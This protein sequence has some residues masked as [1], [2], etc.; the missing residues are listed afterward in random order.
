MFG[1]LFKAVKD[2]LHVWFFHTE[3]I[4]WINNVLEEFHFLFLSDSFS[5]KYIYICTDVS[6]VAEHITAENMS[7]GCFCNIH[8]R[9][10]TNN[11]D[12][13]NQN[14]PPEV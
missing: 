10:L 1:R 5:D 7:L 9:K 4:I 14:I 13:L 12:I 11:T 8:D 3:W 2:K 6:E